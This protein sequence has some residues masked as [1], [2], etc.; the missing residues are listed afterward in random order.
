MAK[1]FEALMVLTNN[2]SPTRSAGVKFGFI[3]AQMSSGTRVSATGL[4]DSVLAKAARSAGPD[5]PSLS[6][7]PGPT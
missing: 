6:W 2:V 1:R 3:R 7:P 4:I 5:R